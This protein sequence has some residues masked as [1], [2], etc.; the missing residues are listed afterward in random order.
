MLNGPR[1][2]EPGLLGELVIHSLGQEMYLEYLVMLEIKH[3]IKKSLNVIPL[4][5]EG[6]NLNIKRE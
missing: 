5:K 1:G 3:A 4:T 2:R 6:D